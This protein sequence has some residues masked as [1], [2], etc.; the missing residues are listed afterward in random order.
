MNLYVNICSRFAPDRD[1]K[2]IQILFK[3]LILLSYESGKTLN[4]KKLIIIL[5][6]TI[7]SHFIQYT[8]KVHRR[9]I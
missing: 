4:K 5:G 1:R 8:H 7:A 6:F 3:E 2:Y 9:K